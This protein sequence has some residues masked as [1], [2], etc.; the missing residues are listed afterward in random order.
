MSSNVSAAS[1]NGSGNLGNGSNPAFHFGRQVRKERLARGMSIHELAALAGI[2]AGHL[3]RLERGQR[4]PTEKVAG[5][6]DR[7]FPERR[8]WFSEY[9]HDS[10]EWAPP[11]YRSWA[12]YENAATALRAWKPGMLHGY[13]QTGAYARGLL[14]SYPGVPAE[15]VEARLQAR[16]VRQERIL[17]REDPASLWAG[18]DEL[19]LY[20]RVTSPETMT[21]QMDHLLAVADLPNV[22]LQVLPAVEHP[23]NASEVIIADTSA[24]YAEHIAGGFVY[25]DTD[26]VSELGRLI[27]TIQAECYR[28]SETVQILGRMRDA[29]A[30]GGKAPIPMPTED[31]A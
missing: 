29:W 20:R 14:K 5:I 15:V 16:M 11:G 30:R 21:E 1:D 9:H 23:V 4:A 31:P 17:H 25:T 6:L 26:T 10:R 18:I 24:A 3:S 8:G 12:E 7:V 19:C 2:S 28:A 13:L 22:T 27:T